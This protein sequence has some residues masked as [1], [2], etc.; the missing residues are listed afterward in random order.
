MVYIKEQ[1]PIDPS[2]DGGDN[3]IRLIDYSYPDIASI[4]NLNDYIFDNIKGHIIEPNVANTSIRV[5]AKETALFKGSK[6]LYYK[7]FNLDDVNGQEW[8]FDNIEDVPVELN[9]VLDF[10]ISQ[11]P[12][13]KDELI[14]ER[15]DRYT[16]SITA[17]DDGYTVFNDAVIIVAPLDTRIPLDEVIGNL[18]LKGLNLPAPPP[19]VNIE[20]EM[21]LPLSGFDGEELNG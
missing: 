13:V 5:T 15:M 7:R 17:V 18:M 21:N 8:L 4:I 6:T 9:D 19:A 1:L 16:Y 20:I 14:I 2:L 3:L 10:F 12:L 11:V